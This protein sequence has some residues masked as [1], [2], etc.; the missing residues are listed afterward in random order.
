MVKDHRVAQSDQNVQ[1]DATTVAGGNASSHGSYLLRPPFENDQ[2]WVTRS[3]SACSQFMSQ[4]VAGMA[5]GTRRLNRDNALA[6]AVMLLLLS[7]CRSVVDPGQSRRPAPAVNAPAV[8]APPVNEG[9][10]P[11][12][13]SN[14]S[15]SDPSAGVEHRPVSSVVQLPQANSKE[16]KYHTAKSG[17][18][19]S[20]LAR[21]YRLTVPELTDANGIDAS[22]ALQPGQMIY[23]PEK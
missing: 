10:G 7:G 6:V 2:L 14:P 12:F 21:Q 11:A 22:T 15:T 20:S 18:S 8:I 5:S 3:A 4:H 13:P 23:I 17:D 19:W 9:S 1:S 16:P